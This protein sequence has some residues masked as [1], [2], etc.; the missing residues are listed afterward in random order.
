M[1]F[2]LLFSSTIFE[3]K[4]IVPMFPVYYIFNGMMLVLF[5][6]QVFWTYFILK[7]CVRAIMKGKVEDSRSSSESLSEEESEP[8][9]KKD[10]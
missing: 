2:G 3:A 1:K 8:G 6:L 5:G 7:V 4:K 10:S 9:S